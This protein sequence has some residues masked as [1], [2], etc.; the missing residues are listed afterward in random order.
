MYL[1]IKSLLLFFRCLQNEARELEIQ[2]KNT[3]L[4]PE[5]PHDN[6]SLNKDYDQIC[7]KYSQVKE[8]KDSNKEF[9]FNPIESNKII[10]EKSIGVSA[11]RRWELK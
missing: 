10:K 7:Y 5:L 4:A 11:K 9:C 6:D 1:L 2:F 3:D 8:N